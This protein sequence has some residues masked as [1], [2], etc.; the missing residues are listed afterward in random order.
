MKKTLLTLLA[1]ALMLPAAA[2][3]QIPNSDFET[4]GN[5]SGEPRYWHGFKSA[6]G[7]W[8]GMAKGTLASSTD[9]HGGNYSAVVTSGKV[10]TVINNGTMT[11]GQLQAA[12]T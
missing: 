3:Y 11:N 7:T 4:W 12:S 10:L 6:K 9:K 2:Q 8:A 5:S 1:A